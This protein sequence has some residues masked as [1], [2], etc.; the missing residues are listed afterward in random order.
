VNELIGFV[1]VA[2][3]EQNELLCQVVPK[4]RVHRCA[5]AHLLAQLKVQVLY[6]HEFVRAMGLLSKNDQKL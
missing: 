3:L 5:D 6:L 2:A 4:L 1:Y